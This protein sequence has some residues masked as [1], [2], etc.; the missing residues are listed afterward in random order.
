MPRVGR[1]KY[2]RAE[3]PGDLWKVPLHYA[4]GDRL[5]G[6]HEETTQGG[7]SITAQPHT[8]SRVAHQGHE[9]SYCNCIPCVQKVM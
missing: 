4:A 9:N 3:T 8:G 6:A 1:I 2:Q 5:T 7:K